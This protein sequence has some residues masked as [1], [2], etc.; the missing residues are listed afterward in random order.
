MP[1]EVIIQAITNI[2]R[3]L[4]QLKQ[5]YGLPAETG[6]EEMY[7]KPVEDRSPRRGTRRMNY[8]DARKKVRGVM[9]EDEKY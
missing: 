7:E 3:E 2:E 5:A 8:N 1:R 9:K 4:E 6:E